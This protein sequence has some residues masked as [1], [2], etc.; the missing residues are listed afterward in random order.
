MKLLAA[1]GIVLFA[2]SAVS[3]EIPEGL[4]QHYICNETARQVIMNFE[5]AQLCALNYAYLKL[6]FV[7]ADLD[8]AT[9]LAL[10][11]ELRAEV[12]REGYLAF[13]QWESDNAELVASL[14]QA[15]E[16]IVGSSR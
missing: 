5:D 2:S 15:A 13:K 4:E 11:V 10:P 7:E 3:Q 12:D 6:Q 16:A 9:Y 1:F 14:Y 8:L